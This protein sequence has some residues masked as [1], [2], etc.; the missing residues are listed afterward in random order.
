[1]VSDGKLLH[2]TSHDRAQKHCRRR[3]VLM[4]AMALLARKSVSVMLPSSHA[5]DSSGAPGTHLNL[6]HARTHRDTDNSDIS[7][8]TNATTTKQ[9]DTEVA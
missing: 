4:V 6:T 7:K 1:M 8:T 2:H 5:T 9:K 3:T